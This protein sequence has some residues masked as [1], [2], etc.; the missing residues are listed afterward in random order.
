MQTKWI[1]TEY[2]LGPYLT[3]EAAR[4]DALHMRKTTMLPAGKHPQLVEVREKTVDDLPSDVDGKL[5]NEVL[6]ALCSVE[7]D[8][9]GSFDWQQLSG[10]LQDELQAVLAKVYRAG[11]RVLPDA[12]WIAAG[13]IESLDGRTATR[14]YGP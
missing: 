4:A 11:I 6:D 14:F 8:G 13:T 7:A 1:V 5:V 2:G 9:F 3:K 10:E 12:D